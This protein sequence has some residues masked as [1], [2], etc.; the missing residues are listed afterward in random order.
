MKVTKP[1]AASPVRLFRR[2]SAALRCSC[3]MPVMWEAPR[4]CSSP[5]Q[6]R[7]ADEIEQN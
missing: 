2:A 6:P 4:R 1:A 7:N 5:E 3:S